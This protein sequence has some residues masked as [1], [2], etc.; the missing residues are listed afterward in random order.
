MAFHARLFKKFRLKIK[1]LY[2]LS[3]EVFEVLICC[4]V[5]Y[6][7]PVKGTY[8]YITVKILNEINIQFLQ[9]C[10]TLFKKSESLQ[11]EACHFRSKICKLND[12]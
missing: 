10:Y 9:Y 3:I 11:T 12:V 8:I 7:N 2:N 5:I 1:E 6:L 4:L